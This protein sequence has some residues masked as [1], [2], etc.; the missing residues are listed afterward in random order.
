MRATA[1]VLLLSLLPGSAALA[2][3]GYWSPEQDAAVVVRMQEVPDK[4]LQAELIAHADKPEQVGRLIFR[5]LEPDE[6][7]AIWRGQVYALRRGRWMDGEIALEAQDRFTLT[8]KT[9]LFSRS[10]HW[11]RVSPPQASPPQ[12]SP[13]PLHPQDP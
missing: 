6:T 10:V 8:V 2:L 7:G 11:R 3:E 1:W 12:A 9:L 13:N 4:T 5:Q